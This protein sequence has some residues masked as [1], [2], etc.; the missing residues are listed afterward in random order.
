[1]SPYVSVW[2]EEFSAD[3]DFRWIRTKTLNCHDNIPA[4]KKKMKSHEINVSEI[5]TV[6]FN[7]I[8]TIAT[9]K[10]CCLRYNL[11][12][13]LMTTTVRPGPRSTR[14]CDHMRVRTPRPVSYAAYCR[15]IIIILLSF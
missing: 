5:K 9:K 2:R 11:V 8:C 1:M 6:Q 13:L 14:D 3:N 12:R 4:V 10:K 7:I 15:T